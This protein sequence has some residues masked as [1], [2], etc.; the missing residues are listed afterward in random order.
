[1]AI[2]GVANQNVAAWFER[3]VSYLETDASLSAIETFK[4]HSDLLLRLLWPNERNRIETTLPNATNRAVLDLIEENLASMTERLEKRDYTAI[5]NLH[6]FKRSGL[7]ERLIPTE[8]ESRLARYQQEAVAAVQNSWDQLLRDLQSLSD[9]KEHNR[10]ACSWWPYGKA[11]LNYFGESLDDNALLQRLA[12]LR[13]ANWKAWL[14]ELFNEI[15]ATE[16]SATQMRMTFLYDRST[17]PIDRDRCP[18]W[19]QVKVKVE[20]R[21]KVLEYEGF[22]RRVGEGP[23]GPDYPGAILLNAIYRNDRKQIADESRLLVEGAL[24][25]LHPVEGIGAKRSTLVKNH[26]DG[27]SEVLMDGVYYSDPWAGRLHLSAR[28]STFVETLMS[29]FGASYL[30]FYPDCAESDVVT[31]NSPST[32]SILFDVSK[33]STAP[34]NSPS[35]RLQHPVNRRHVPALEYVSTRGAEKERAYV[36]GTLENSLVVQKHVDVYTT[37]WSHST[38]SGVSGYMYNSIFQGDWEDAKEELSLLADALRGLR[39]AMQERSCD[40]PVIQQLDKQLVELVADKVG[41]RF[42]SPRR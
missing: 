29:F 23:F 9:P 15:D 8:I 33:G 11:S 36:P 21:I 17:Q 18:T 10:V 39:R 19:Q 34:G 37:V 5:Y 22:L 3:M 28:R 40:D 32:T 4:A 30:Q 2:A 38:T 7:F 27:Y 31:M 25:A 16:L 12:E 35:L 42:L 1:M 20:E 24:R 26:G 6:H 13:E 41:Q 14:P